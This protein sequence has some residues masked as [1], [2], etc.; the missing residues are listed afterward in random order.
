V[1][2]ASTIKPTGTPLNR[3]AS[4]VVKPTGAFARSALSQ[5]LKKEIIISPTTSPAISAS[6]IPIHI[7]KSVIINLGL[8]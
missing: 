4:K 1:I 3:I 2:L 5:V 7:I 8:N 6:P